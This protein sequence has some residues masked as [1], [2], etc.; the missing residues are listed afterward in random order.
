MKAFNVQTSNTDPL[1]EP[2]SLELL[3]AKRDWTNMEKGK[4]LL[5]ACTIVFWKRL[6]GY[7]S[8][9]TGISCQKSL[10]YNGRKCSRLAP[11]TESQTV[12]W[13]HLHDIGYRPS[14]GKS[15]GQLVSYCRGDGSDESIIK[16]VRKFTSVM[17]CT[18]S[19]VIAKRHNKTSV[20]SWLAIK[21]LRPEIHFAVVFEQ[22]GRLIF[23]EEK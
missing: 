2:H 6:R 3:Y 7:F 18:W 11:V 12:A 1:Y 15:A 21:S 16:Y 5:R 23:L 19:S 20:L 14:Q 9:R 8:G 13:A 4:W 17:F 22:F 10:S